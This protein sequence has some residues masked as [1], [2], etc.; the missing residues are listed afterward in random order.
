[1][2]NPDY[3]LYKYFVELIE[4]LLPRLPDVVQG[5]YRRLIN[6]NTYGT[7]KEPKVGLVFKYTNR[8]NIKQ[9]MRAHVTSSIA[10]EKQDATCILHFMIEDPMDLE[11]ELDV[12][13]PEGPMDL[14]AE[15]DVAS[16]E[17]GNTMQDS[18][19]DKAS[20]LEEELDIASSEGEMSC[21]LQQV[22]IS[23]SLARALSMLRL[24][25]VD[26]PPQHPLPLVMGPDGCTGRTGI[27]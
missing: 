10:N 16:S 9:Q 21:L 2:L 7:P 23:S 8:T 3:S 22:M 18:T 1:M 13:S 27:I 26:S 11:V 24:V 20:D 17:W 19:I 6:N 4:D 5:H 15:L 14:E 25:I 12:A